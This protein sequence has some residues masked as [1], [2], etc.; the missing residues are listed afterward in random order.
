VLLSTKTTTISFFFK[1]LKN[2]YCGIISLDAALTEMLRER[3]KFDKKF[4]SNPLRAP[5]KSV[6]A[7]RW[8]HEPPWPLHK[9]ILKKWRDTI[10]TALALK[11]SKA[12]VGRNFMF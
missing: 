11:I 12:Q 3:L 4:N 9:Y 8:T 6:H 5:V 10:I 7:T 1:K 2:M